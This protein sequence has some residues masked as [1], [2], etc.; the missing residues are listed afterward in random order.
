M[1]NVYDIM[2][3]HI[4]NYTEEVLT[5]PFISE[6]LKEPLSYNIEL[7]KAVAVNMA[8]VEGGKDI[9]LTEA[10]K[11]DET[12]EKDYEKIFKEA[13]Q[14]RKTKGKITYEKIS[15]LGYNGDIS[16]DFDSPEKEINNFIKMKKLSK[17]GFYFDAKGNI[18]FN[19]NT[20][21][22]YVLSRYK[23][24]RTQTGNYYIY[25]VESG[26]YEAKDEIFIAKLFRDIM[27][28]A[29]KDIWRKAYKTEY[30]DALPLEIP[31]IE[32]MN[33]CKNYINLENGMLN[34]N[35]MILEQHN[36]KFYSSVRI[37]INYN[38]DAKCVKFDKFIAD[39]MDDDQDRINIIGEQLGYSL[40][41]ET[42]AEKFFVWYGSG[43]NGKSLLSKIYKLV[44][45]EENVSNLSI[46]DLCDKFGLARIPDKT[47]NISNENESFGKTLNTQNL[48]AIASG[49]RMN[50]NVK[51]KDGFDYS[52]ICKLV[53][54]MNTLPNVSDNTDGFYRKMLILP[55]NKTFKGDNQDKNLYQK[56]AEEKEG[57]LV[58]A[59]NG[60]KRLRDN[61]YSFTK[62]EVCEDILG[63]YEKENNPMIEFIDDCLSV[64]NGARTSNKDMLDEFKRLADGNGRDD[65]A[66]MS[67]QAFWKLFKLVLAKRGI[68]YKTGKNN[69]DRYIEDFKL[70]NQTNLTNATNV[71]V[72]SSGT[73]IRF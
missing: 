9:F 71:I 41:A 6:V 1:E 73:T 28:E 35:T 39:I 27:H 43:A 33:E 19:V 34:L 56:L 16:K 2:D 57:I 30:M 44:C 13:E 3:G 66:K 70:V 36:P 24:V 4:E 12:E 46:N 31:N 50:I 69:G 63:S 55:F 25:N 21:L 18:R 15:L 47:L 65:I 52:P 10:L 8:Y 40:T 5:V 53:F 14:Y 64:V 59:L 11:N 20:F 54:L 60:L 48:K 58:F 51:Y 23:I 26:Y 45:G 37:P 67:A 42:K 38:P 72:N 32:K 17:R 62:S 22:R 29:A 49:D 61:N 68:T 7:L